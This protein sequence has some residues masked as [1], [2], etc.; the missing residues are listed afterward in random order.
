MKDVASIVNT[1]GLAEIRMLKRIRAREQRRERKK[2][3]TR[4][5]T[6]VPVSLKGKR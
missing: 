3:M 1:K 5:T 4:D 6:C 2:R